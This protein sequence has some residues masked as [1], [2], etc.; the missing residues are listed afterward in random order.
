MTQL[1]DTKPK[2]ATKTSKESKL[3]YEVLYGRHSD[4][5][6][7]PLSASPESSAYPSTGSALLDSF[8]SQAIA[9]PI[10]LQHLTLIDV[11]NLRTKQPP[12]KQA[13]ATKRP[14]V[15]TARPQAK[16]KPPKP[17]ANPLLKT[18]REVSP[19]SEAPPTSTETAPAPSVPSTQ[20][21]RK[22]EQP[23]ISKAFSDQPPAAAEPDTID[24]TAVD[25]VGSAIQQPPTQRPAKTQ[26]PASQQATENQTV[27]KPAIDKS[28][29]EKPPGP[30]QSAPSAAAVSP[31]PATH[32]R[33]KPVN[34]PI[35]DSKVARDSAAAVG[36]IDISDTLLFGGDH[37]NLASTDPF[38]SESHP[39]GSETGILSYLSQ[40]VSA[41]TVDELQNGFPHNTDPKVINRPD[42]PKHA[43]VLGL[44]HFKLGKLDEKAAIPSQQTDNG[45]ARSTTEPE[46]N[47][48][49]QQVN[50][51][52]RKI[53]ELSQK[54][55]QV[56][57]E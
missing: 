1:S 23:L 22:P 28:P 37:Q 16:T 49:S 43:T 45:N 39:Q 4:G 52:N 5:I 54:L 31:V 32:T 30:R 18:G 3:G 10:S 34:A 38:I 24:L 20:D 35:S 51:L 36:L 8:V 40:Q 7:V 29:E 41:F 12:T 55:A 57:Q 46:I 15:N 42:P 44:Q 27:A 48:L 2:T 17:P 26:Q 47:A 25:S 13:I 56:T 9:E 6:Q 21:S 14:E 33:T 19:L 50:D 11:A 53:A